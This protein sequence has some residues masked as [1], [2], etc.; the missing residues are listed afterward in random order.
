ME[1]IRSLIDDLG[2]N[3]NRVLVFLLL[4]FLIAIGAAITPGCDA[5]PISIPGPIQNDDRG[6]EDL[7]PSGDAT[8]SL[9]GDASAAETLDG[10]PNDAAELDGGVGTTDGS[11]DCADSA[12][13]N[14]DCSDGGMSGSCVDAD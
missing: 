8:G 14:L 4:A 3:P 5:T 6:S 9:S 13:D 10:G 7:E 11:L 1:R 2:S 12:D